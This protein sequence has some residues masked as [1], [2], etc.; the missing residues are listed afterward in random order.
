M[1]QKESSDSNDLTKKERQVIRKKGFILDAAKK[2][3]SEK[4]FESITMEEIAESAALSRA[5]VYNYFSAKEEIYFNI[6]IEGIGKW[7]EEYHS[8]DLSKY[9]GK[10]VV[11]FL[12]EKLIEGILEFPHYSKLLRRFFDRSHD[13]GIPIEEIF[14]NNILKRNKI[15]EDDP[16][17]QYQVFFDLLEFYIKYRQIWQDAIN[18]G[19]NDDSIVS[20]SN[21]YHLNFII[22]MLVLGFLDQVDFRRSL[23]EIVD[24]RN[25]DIKDF[26]LTLV[27]KVLEGEIQANESL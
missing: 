18:N 1:S 17:E 23:M 10:E 26:L 8:R 7:I 24:I 19:I 16:T 12:A 4:N 2:L 6:G 25:D 3:F 13:L 20:T 21:P 22:I 27:K 9:T 11:L 15:G 5:T 14:Y